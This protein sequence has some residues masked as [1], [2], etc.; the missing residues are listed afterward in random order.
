MPIRCPGCMKLKMS[1]PVCEH[2]GFDE[3]T[4]NASHQLPVGTVLKEQ[5]RIGK[6]LGQGGFGITYLGWDLY[7][8]IP[9]AIKEYY[10]NGLV[11]RESAVGLDVLSCEGEGSSRF[12][13]NKDRFL[14]EAK[15]LA[16]FSQMPEIVQVKNFFLANNTAYIAMEYVE[17][18]TLKRY[19]KNSGGTLTAE[20]TLKLLQPV[21]RALG[22]VHK[23][24]LI[25]RDISPDNIMM[26]PNGDV[27]LLDFGA[28][29]DVGSA[30]VGQNLTSSTESILKPGYAPIEQYQKRGNLGPWTDVY[31]L[32]GTIYFCLTGEVP[33]DAPERMLEFDGEGLF[34]EITGLSD[35]QREALEQG[36]AIRT[37]QRTASMEELYCKLY[38]EKPQN[39]PKAPS[40]QV[41]LD[42]VPE[43]EKKLPEQKEPAKPVQKQKKKK[44]KRRFPI[45][46]MAVLLTCGGMLAFHLTRKQGTMPPLSI[47]VQKGQCGETVTWSLDLQTGELLLEGSGQMYNYMSPEEA[48]TYSDLPPWYGYRAKIRTLT[49]DGQV[50]TIG[51]YAFADC[52]A[53]SSAE[54]GDTIADIGEG[55]FSGTAL[56]NVTIPYQV[57]T[58]GSRAFA[59]CG[60][61]EELT[62][63]RDT[64][65]SYDT[66]EGPLVTD[67]NGNIPENF[68]LRGFS[69]TLAEDY[70]GIFGYHFDT[71][72]GAYWDAQGSCGKLNWYLDFET[73]L[74][75]I[76]GEGTMPDFNGSWQDQKWE[77]GYRSNR[78]MAP[79]SEYK[80]KIK[81]VSIGDGVANIGANAFEWCPALK[82][83]H[84][85]SGVK[86]I[87]HS[88]FYTNDID[89]LVL[90]D[91][92]QQIDPYAVRWCLDL[93]YVRLP[94]GLEELQENVFDYCQNI[95]TC[96]VGPGTVLRNETDT[97]F[98]PKTSVGI[99]GEIVIYG[100]PGSD[101]ERFCEDYSF[102]EF[103][104]GYEGA[105]VDA[106]GQCGNELFWFKSGDQL[107][108]YGDGDSWLYQISQEERE[109]WAERDWPEEY[110][111]EGTPDFYPYRNE[112]THIRILP[113]VDGLNHRLFTDFSKLQSVDFG[114]VR[115]THMCMN[116]CALEYAYIPESM[117]IVGEYMFGWCENLRIVEVDGGGESIGEGAFTGCTNLEQ[118][119]FG[120]QA[121]FQEAD[122]LR[123]HPDS[124]YSDKV[125]LFVKQGSAAEQYARQYGMEYGYH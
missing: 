104:A 84:I 59:G 91:T 22:K 111:Q 102:P 97:P 108:L 72:A 66:W 61:L 65:I 3:R 112:I 77:K 49:V 113:G 69:K 40:R 110:L 79:W 119:W 70:A 93:K 53:L 25:H 67:E 36:M 87:G 4:A 35:P 41:V 125:I 76:D 94:V 105:A 8:D 75:K 99:P 90:P 80:G 118:L 2:C 82:D 32:C 30:M 37:D 100:I 43:P 116:N 31:A 15:M 5:Y 45:L 63:Y 81:I 60:Q 28:G 57:K 58:I 120:A 124:T 12:L 1:S 115:E 68:T 17:G 106:N 107:V 86:R 96:Y 74:L 9:L 18:I 46:L 103:A 56:T 24:G 83:V 62:I 11:M 27:K 33:P 38:E 121:K 117:E 95:R 34:T 85:G 51:E 122:I 88:A 13:Q 52:K 29:R 114:T 42:P 23:T 92:V 21:I 39:E 123:P 101:A 44:R 6:V 19:V 7:L 109:Q 78:T 50:E 64:A 73:G 10:P 55:A 47:G 54:L 14:R 20:E 16:R 26:L 71:I 48:P 98:G 89:Q